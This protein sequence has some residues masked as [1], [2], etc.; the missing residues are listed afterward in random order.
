MSSR[1]VRIAKITRSVAHAALRRERLFDLLDAARAYP[2][3]WI[4]GPPGA[5]KTTLV[6]SYIETGGV[7]HLWY[8]VD[9]GDH[10]PAS[11]F[12][13]LTRAAE[14]VAACELPSLPRYTPGGDTA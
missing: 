2:A 6:S 8:K 12:A 4:A 13:Y 10:D 3:T 1:A 14:A 9:A 5:G 7:P 11:L